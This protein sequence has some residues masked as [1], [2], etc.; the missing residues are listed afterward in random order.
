MKT[1]QQSVYEKEEK[2]REKSMQFAEAM[3]LFFYNLWRQYY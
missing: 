2:V 1:C 3:P